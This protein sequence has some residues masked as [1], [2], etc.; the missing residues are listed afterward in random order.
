MK[1]T[2]K[3]KINQISIKKKF[4]NYGDFT[5]HNLENEDLSFLKIKQETT[6]WVDD[7]NL[8]NTG[9]P[10]ALLPNCTIS[11]TDLSSC[12]LFLE[13]KYEWSNPLKFNNVTFDKKQIE[14]LN[15]IYKENRFKYDAKTLLNND[16]LYIPSK[17]LLDIIK[18]YLRYKERNQVVSRK[19]LNEQLE[20]VEKLI[21][22]DIDGHLKKLYKFI[23]KDMHPFE[24]LNVFKDLQL[25]NKTLKDFTFDD[26]TYKLF[27]EFEID[28]CSLE[29][30]VFN[31]TAKSLF[32]NNVDHH[33]ST[34]TNIQMPNLK[35]DYIE[36]IGKR[37]SRT[38][39][40][41]QKNLYLELS[42]DCNGDCKFCRNHFFENKPYNLEKMI[43]TINENKISFSN[44]NIGGGEPTLR[45]ADLE[46]L[47]ESTKL[48]NQANN[49]SIVSNG[50]KD[51]EFYRY[52]YY[53]YGIKTNISRHSFDDKINANILGIDNSKILNGEILEEIPSLSFS[54]TCI[55]G[56]ID[57]L[58]K[59]IDYINYAFDIGVNNILFCN[60]QDTASVENTTN[61][62]RSLSID[63]NIF[64]ETIEFL[65]RQ[66]YTFK[67]PII[68][69]GGYKLYILKKGLSTISF[70]Q[71]ISKEDLLNLW[72]TAIK[73]TYDFSLSPDG[74]L[75]SDW[76]ETTEND[77]SKKLINK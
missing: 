35:M 26:E 47:I 37:I 14:F 30:I 13:T 68:S 15:S 4:K 32:D 75:Y 62:D 21:D 25:Y 28:H 54:C 29:N 52:L 46:K 48:Y 43:N 73:R 31:N 64:I 36:S 65:Q 66:N 39:F 42:R 1:E 38:P 63:E 18:E 40:T 60:L 77:Y 58:D 8:K 69:T 44:I 7:A 9:L 59:I 10:L 20:I 72:P 34:L 50:S 19:Y 2:I 53:E 67:Y 61:L 16:N 27:Q 49:V 41:F 24:I 11:N 51:Y 3:R 6:Y 74:N 71:Y 45:H 56:G 76:S 57:S 12:N 70:K 22:K 33:Y 55:K 23:T 5:K 17:V